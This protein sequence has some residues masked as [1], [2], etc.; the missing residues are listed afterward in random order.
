MEAVA[1]AMG[2][3][4]DT[5]RLHAGL[6]YTLS[7]QGL[8]DDYTHGDLDIVGPGQVEIIGDGAATTVIDANHIDRIFNVA[9]HLEITGVTLRNGKPSTASHTDG[10]AILVNG[11]NVTV[12]RCVLDSNDAIGHYGGA[13]AATSSAFLVMTGTTIR[14]NAASLGGGI[15]TLGSFVTIRMSAIVQNSSGNGGGL[16]QNNG[17]STIENSTFALNDSTGNGGGISIGGGTLKLNNATVAGNLAD[18]DGDGSGLGGGIDDGA[19][20]SIVVSNSIFKNSNGFT[21]DVDDCHATHDVNDVFYLINF[22]FAG[23]PAPV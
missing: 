10:G 8:P 12:E 1:D 18:S 19:P 16:Y 17:I 7:Q 15:A 9:G 22:L 2:G 5:I 4:N 14:L 3:L 23:G 13:I 21:H 11:G 6:P 20:I